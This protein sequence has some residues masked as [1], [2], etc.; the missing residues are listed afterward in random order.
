MQHYWINHNGQQQGPFTIEELKRLELSDKAYVWFNGLSDWV[1]IG[2]VPELA[3]LLYEP[4]TASAADVSVDTDPVVPE[5]PEAPIEQ[6]PMTPP[7]GDPQP[8]YGAQPPFGPQPPFGAES[9]MPDYASGQPMQQMPLGVNPEYASM[10]TQLPPEEMPKCPPS[11]LWWA[12]GTTV[13]CCLPLGIAAI[14]M[15]MK[16]GQCY[17]AGDYEGS[18][19]WSDRTAWMCIASIIFGIIAMPLQFLS[20]AF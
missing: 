17:R 1:K 14:F 7:Y 6:P 13:L 4:P 8:P 11:N 3:G 10:P 18:V 20:M 9:P 12:I 15:S 2:E 16:V 19:K 5:I